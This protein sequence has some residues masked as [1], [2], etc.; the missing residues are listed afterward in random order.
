MNHSITRLLA[1]AGLS[2][3]AIAAPARA[4]L[5]VN[6]DFASGGLSPGW[7]GQNVVVSSGAFP[8]YVGNDVVNSGC[9]GSP[10]IDPTSPEASFFSQSVT[11]TSGAYNLSEQVNQGIGTSGK[12]LAIYW[13]GVLVAQTD[14]TFAPNVFDL[15]QVDDLVAVSGVN[16]LTEFIE[17]DP[18]VT[19]VGAIVLE[20]ANNTPPI[21]EPTSL[22]M[23]AASLIGLGLGRRRFRR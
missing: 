1:A 20:A 16:T 10:C 4:N 13:D 19:E 9:V 23:F 18:S 11:L 17:N 7:S 5:L 21:P 12:E 8:P 14:S 6:G 22:A 3:I 15:Y 2:L